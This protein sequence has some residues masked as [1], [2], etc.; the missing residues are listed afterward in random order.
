MTRHVRMGA[1]VALIINGGFVLLDW[2]IFRDQFLLF[3]CVRAAMAAVLGGILLRTSVSYPRISELALCLSLGTGMLAMIY[4]DGPNS[5]YFA[6]L[7]LLFVGMGVLLPL[8][9]IEAAGVCG[10]IIAGF[11]V[12]PVLA[13]QSWDW[14]TFG[15][16]AFFLLAAAGES[17]GSCAFLDR[18]RFNDFAQRRALEAARD[19]LKEMDRAKSR[20]TSNVHHELRTPLTLVLASIES[21][22]DRDLGLDERSQ[23]DYLESAR[24]NGLRLLKLINNLLDLAKLESQRLAIRRRPVN[25]GRIAL[26]L[27]VGAR[28]MAESKGV[29]LD[30]LSLEDLPSIHADPDAVE[31][32]LLNLIG[33]ALKFTEPGGRIEVRGEAT[34]DGLRMAVSDSGIGLPEDEL[35]RVFDRFAQ[36]DASATRKHE[37][38]GIGLALAKELVTLH[39]GRIWAE[40]AGP[41]RGSTFWVSLPEGEADEAEEEAVLETREGRAAALGRSLAGIEAELDIEQRDAGE[42]RLSDLAHNVERHRGAAPDAEAEPA[43]DARALADAAEVLVVEDNGAMRRLLRTI[44]E[45]EFRVR[46]AANGRLGLEAVRASKPDVV[47]TDIMMPEMS[48]TELCQALKA[49]PQTRD[50]PVILVTSKGEREMRLEGLELGAQDY[51]TKP[52]HH[53]ELLA[54]VRSFSRLHRLQDELAQRNR[55]LERRTAE[56]EAAQ[57]QLVQSE[58]LA[59]VGELAAGVAHEV[60]NPVNFAVNSLQGIR[61]RVDVLRSLIAALDKLDPGDPEG[62]DAQLDALERHKREVGFEEL[63]DELEELVAIVA[64][65]L[66]RTH[67]LVADLR[68]F[69]GSRAGADT[70]VDVTLGLRTTL[71]L[72]QHVL[73]NAGVRVET[74]FAPHLPTVCGAPEGLNQVFLNLLKNSTDALEGRGGTIRVS[75]R[76][77]GDHVVVA[78]SDD[79][80][81]IDPV[82]RDRL[83]EPFASTKEAGK[84]TGLGLSVSRRI[85]TRLGGT[86]EV[87]APEA[88]GATFEVRLPGELRDAS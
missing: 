11:G 1:S 82:V 74:D 16:H 57:V 44:L 5:S 43:E 83:F 13:T 10:T 63:A 49:D 22:L 73:R 18:L 6:G 55:A 41:G 68:D 48:G 80:P 26:D 85:V 60:N 51:V 20:F 27:A 24:V 53:R 7:I 67:R 36:V 15:V 32:V 84:G 76:R 50:V 14:T 72:M 4:V 66:D 35:E 37:G 62:L 54:R 47:L 25:V 56:L 33:N 40:S 75:A 58:R 29:V 3:F 65:G 12:S 28:P 86:L 21:I 30:T 2:A 45:R 81:G 79:G 52:F 88:R 70:S 17:V 42:Y 64:E 46:T 38:T 23:R 31:K 19:E 59:A 71:R 39:G 9:A 34:A 69:A 61:S 77:D 78:V 87:T 8:T